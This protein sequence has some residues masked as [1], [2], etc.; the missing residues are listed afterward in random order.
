MVASQT[1]PAPPA[2]QQKPPQ[3][4]TPPTLQTPPQK[5]S[6][7]K[8]IQNPRSI[9]HLNGN[10]L[11]RI[12]Q[13]LPGNSKV[14]L[15]SSSKQFNKTVSVTRLNILQSTCTNINN[16][17][18]YHRNLY[19]AL[20]NSDTFLKCMKLFSI[21]H[22]W[23]IKLS[24]TENID[25]YI[26]FLRMYH[27]CAKEFIHDIKEIMHNSTMALKHRKKEMGRQ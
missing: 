17:I 10:A 22:E 24:D 26:E 13:K 4:Q 6:Q 27:F 1:V 20:E 23:F 9:A 14:F 19:L 18:V 25:I 3:P 5:P 12:F 15:K 11:A 7:T 21:M 2:P 16:N 8:N